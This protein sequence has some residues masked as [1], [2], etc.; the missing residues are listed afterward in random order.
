MRKI[1]LL[2]LMMVIISSSLC[3]ANDVPLQKAY[4]YYFQGKM[5]EAIAIMEDYASKHPDARVLY[6]IGYAYYELK[7][8]RNANRYFRDAYLVDPDFTPLPPKRDTG[9]GQG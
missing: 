6:F 3:L 4:S 9:G 7:D 1:I 2:V 8:F 5:V